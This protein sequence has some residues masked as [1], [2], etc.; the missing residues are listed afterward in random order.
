MQALPN[1]WYRSQLDEVKSQPTR[2]MN[3]KLSEPSASYCLKGPRLRAKHLKG[4][5]RQLLGVILQ[6]EPK[7]LS[8]VSQRTA[9]NWSKGL[10]FKAVTKV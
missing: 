5:S 9:V 10:A 6:N 3:T 4:E 7:D 8:P 2:G 1:S